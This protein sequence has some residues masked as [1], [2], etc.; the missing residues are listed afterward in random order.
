MARITAVGLRQLGD[1]LDEAFSEEVDQQVSQLM[2]W[3]YQ[4]AAWQIARS[5]HGLP[6][7]VT[8]SDPSSMP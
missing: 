4:A 7:V 8:R 6:P 1:L 3:C 5:S 2:L